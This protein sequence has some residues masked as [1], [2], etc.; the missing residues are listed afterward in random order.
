VKV[1]GGLQRFPFWKI[2]SEVFIQ[3][4]K[5]MYIFCSLSYYHGRSEIHF[6]HKNLQKFSSGA[7]L[8]LVIFIHD[9]VEVQIFDWRKSLEEL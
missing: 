4:S 9:M 2:V 1:G 7:G 6:L 8:L 3:T 5:N